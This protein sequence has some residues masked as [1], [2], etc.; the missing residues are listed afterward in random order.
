[1]TPCP[2]C[3]LECW[4]HPALHTGTTFFFC[5]EGF[6]QTLTCTLNGHAGNLPDLSRRGDGGV[7]QSQ[8]IS[9]AAAFF[10]SLVFWAGRGYNVDLW[11]LA[12]CYVAET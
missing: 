3:D 1:M 2:T 5:M 7:E 11:D 6:P 9:S 10:P 12:F 8:T 4:D